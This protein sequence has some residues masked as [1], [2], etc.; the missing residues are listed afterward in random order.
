MMKA[1]EFAE[2]GPAL[3]PDTG[4]GRI[5]SYPD[6]SPW[7]PACALFSSPWPSFSG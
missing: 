5:R 1:A 6:C 2:S 3:K 7:R 4:R